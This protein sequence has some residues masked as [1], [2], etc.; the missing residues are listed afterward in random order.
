MLASRR[1]S[2]NYI[3]TLVQ[4]EETLQGADHVLH[5]E[6]KHAADRHAPVRTIQVRKIY[7]PALSEETKEMIGERD[8]LRA[9][10]K[11][12]HDPPGAATVEGSH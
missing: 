12:S 2:T 5:R 1:G 10:Y 6:L 9:D 8:K 4:D 7:L 11:L 3:N